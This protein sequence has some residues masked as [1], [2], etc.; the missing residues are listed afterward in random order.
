MPVTPCLIEDALHAARNPGIRERHSADK[1]AHVRMAWQTSSACNQR[2][3]IATQIGRCKGIIG[4]KP[5]AR[6]VEN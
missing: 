1:A 6:K 4:P 2:W 3:R 5:K